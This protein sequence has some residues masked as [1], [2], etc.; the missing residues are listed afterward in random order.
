VAVGA[1]SGAIGAAA[2]AVGAAGVAAVR[3]AM[4]PYDQITI[5]TPNP[6]CRL[7][8][9]LI[10]F[11]DWSTVSHVGIFYLLCEALPH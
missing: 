1:T 4:R 9:F 5:K 11:I 7:Y 10:E 3:A 6:K 2:G 8:W